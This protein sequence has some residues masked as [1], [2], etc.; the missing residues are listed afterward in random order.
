MYLLSFVV[1]LALSEP[2]LPSNPEPHP[3][4]K[5]VF[6][7]FLRNK[8]SPPSLA[9]N[10]LVT[11]RLY[12]DVWGLLPTPEQLASPAPLDQLLADNKLYTGHWI[13]FWND[14]L[15]N[16]ESVVY[17]GDR[18]SIT[19]WLRKAL[20]ENLPYDKMLQ[21][22]LNPEEKT[23]PEG[24]LIGVNWRGDINASQMPAMQ[25]AQNTAQVFLGINLKCNSCH[26]SFI[27]RWKLKDAYGLASFFSDSPLEIHRCDAPTGMKAEAK[28]L[29]PELGA[30]D[31]SASL[32]EKRAT[33]ARLFTMPENGRMPRT[34]VNRVWKTLFGRGI[35]EPVDD[36][37][38]APWSPELLDWLAVDFVNHGY[39][40]K[41]LLRRIM[42]SRTYRLASVGEA[43][44]TPYT[45]RG[46][47]P[48]RLTAEQFADAVSAI[49]GEWRMVEPRVP[50]N[51]AYARD[52]QLKSSPLGRALGRP[53]RDYVTT[54]RITQ[55]TT[56]QA[57]ELSNGATLAA[58][59]HRGALRMLNR[60]PPAPRPLFDSGA[61]NNQKVACE[62]DVSSLKRLWF[63]IQ[64]VDSY[65]PARTLPLW[66][67]ARFDDAPIPVNMTV[68]STKILAV[69]KGAKR[70]QAT[71]R[72]DQSSL[73]SDISPRIRFF[74]HAQAPDLK[75][76]LP[77]SG[78]P[79]IARAPANI[80]RIYQHALARQPSSAERK[81]LPRKLTP[82]DLEDVLWSVFLS[83]EFQYIR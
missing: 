38:A 19:P 63:H 62:I 47:H 53:I 52:W 11:R 27:S 55:P 8:I 45:F 1:T 73:A 57:L 36:M 75:Q 14:H 78:E 72:I 69:P 20:E 3:V 58:L 44:A 29:Y 81:L 43:F 7:Y 12:L 51:A 13:T 16:D 17:H 80:D 56:L 18:K 32:A 49:T 42:T 22:L 37:D 82:D 2:P 9:N 71:V 15:R 33:A 66:E 70:F 26:D 4:D 65:D 54:D 30:V 41:H 74:I 6:D 50:G 64:D 61:I 59:L 25:A 67:N 79:L 34:F 23:G 40:I 24:F 5:F 68:S 31:T 10:A 28:F 35:V 46:P 83:P 76:L 60:L 21:A 77:V 39:D 48:R